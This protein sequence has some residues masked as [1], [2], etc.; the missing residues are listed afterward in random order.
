M[1]AALSIST[2]ETTA[3]M[4]IEPDQRDQRDRRPEHG[5][6]AGR[7]IDD[8][9]KDEQAPALAIPRRLDAGDDGEHAVDQHIGREQDDEHL[10][11]RAP[12]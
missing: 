6:G 2:P 7:E 5:D 3:H 1:K 9:F 12:A 4:A 10:R 8:A 11:P